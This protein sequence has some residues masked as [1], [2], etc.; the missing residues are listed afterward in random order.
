MAE[1]RS[2]M[3]GMLF[4][5]ESSKQP[6]GRLETEVNPEMPCPFY[7]A[8]M[9]VGQDKNNTK[10]FKSGKK[11]IFNKEITKPPPSKL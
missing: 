2:P 8:Q 1:G 3:I 11:K 9:G 7:L 5:V 4:R 10:L 6:L